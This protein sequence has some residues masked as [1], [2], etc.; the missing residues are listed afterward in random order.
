MDMSASAALSRGI[1]LPHSIA[2]LALLLSAC[3]AK[4]IE[5]TEEVR[6]SNNETVLVKRTAKLKAN[7]IAGGGGGS[8][9][10]GMTVEIVQPVRPDNPGLWS[11]RFVPLVF[12]RDAITGEW[13]MV[14]TFFHCDSWNELGRPRLPYTEYRYRQGQWIQQSLSA[15][16]I[17]TPANMFTGMGPSGVKNL[18]VEDK[19][20]LLENPAVSPKYKTITDKWLHGC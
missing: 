5:W 1:D 3:G 4:T 11:A 17:G 9:N 16:L 8:I 2:A 14:A 20:L 15:G 6:L 13:F 19:T 18:K 7:Y 10:E 12:D